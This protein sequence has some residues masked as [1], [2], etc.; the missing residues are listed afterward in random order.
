M[1]NSPLV[2]TKIYD[3]PALAHLIQPK[4]CNTFND[5]ASLLFVLYIKGQLQKVRSCDLVWDVYL[6]ESLKQFSCI[7][8]VKGKIHR[9]LGQCKIPQ[10]LNDFL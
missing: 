5:Y 2:D 4:G 3:G 8:H 9:V 10:K 7:Q 6:L 1:V